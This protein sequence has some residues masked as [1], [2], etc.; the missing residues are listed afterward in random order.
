MS[1]AIPVFPLHAFM[2]RPGTT[3]DYYSLVGSILTMNV[4]ETY[5]SNSDCRCVTGFKVLIFDA[6]K[7]VQKLM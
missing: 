1:A 6:G 5:V 2:V 3:I 7:D 4:L